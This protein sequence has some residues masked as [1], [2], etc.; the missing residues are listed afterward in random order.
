MDKTSWAYTVCPRSL[1]PTLYSNLL[2]KMG[3]DYLDNR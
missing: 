1:G 3:Q 2:F